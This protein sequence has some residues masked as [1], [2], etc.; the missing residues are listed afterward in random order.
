MKF[1][2]C[3]IAPALFKEVSVQGPDEAP[4]AID[5][6]QAPTMDNLVPTPQCATF[7][8]CAHALPLASK[9]NHLLLASTSKVA[10]LLLTG[11]SFPPGTQAPISMLPGTPIAFSGAPQYTLWQEYC[12]VDS[13][14]LALVHL[15]PL[16]LPQDAPTQSQAQSSNEAPEAPQI[17]FISSE[18][19]ISNSD[20][21]DPPFRSIY[22]SNLRELVLPEFMWKNQRLNQVN[23]PR[24]IP[25]VPT[26]KPDFGAPNCPVRAFRYYHRYMTEHP[27]LRKGKCHLFVR[28]KD[29]IAGKE[30][31]AASISQWICTAIVNSH[32]SLQNSKSIAGKVKVHEVFITA[33]Q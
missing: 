8:T 16:Q 18:G 21:E 17:E 11:P 31:S 12:G 14:C 22:N 29:K 7:I 28:F 6:G 19:E 4:P 13:P 1:E 33:V 3:V 5:A 30:L 20:K 2:P 27:E 23:D 15:W 26:G 25:E 10:P 24:Y 32:A 9:C